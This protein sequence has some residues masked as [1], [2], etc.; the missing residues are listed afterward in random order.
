MNS[1]A[2]W[3]AAAPTPAV[4]CRNQFCCVLVCFFTA[5][6]LSSFNVEVREAKMTGE[7]CWCYYCNEK[8]CEHHT[9]SY[10]YYSCYHDSYQHAAMLLT[11]QQ[12]VN[13]QN[14]KSLPITAPPPP[15]QPHNHHHRRHHH[16]TTTTTTTTTATTTT[17]TATA[18]PT[19]PRPR[20]PPPSPT[21]TT[22]TI[23]FV[24][25]LLTDNC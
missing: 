14:P 10:H 25:M 21:P 18:T 13:F 24:A 17:A 19:P 8:R 5:R 7:A 3:V 15:P 20:P 23:Y 6:Y 9:S 12:C 2:V 1:N 11:L 16:N 22:T 4:W